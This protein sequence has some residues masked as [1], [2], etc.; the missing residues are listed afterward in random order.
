[1]NTLKFYILH[2][3]LFYVSLARN[4]S[5][6]YNIIFYT[7]DREFSRLARHQIILE[8]FVTSKY[9]RKPIY[10]NS[11]QLAKTFCSFDSR[12]KEKQGSLQRWR[13]NE[14]RIS[15]IVWYPGNRIV[16]TR[17]ALH[18]VLGT[19][20]GHGNGASTGCPSGREWHARGPR[21]RSHARV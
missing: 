12:T 13:T 4:L 19:R 5:N 11:S 20:R 10:Y 14:S 2:F 8:S 7:R 18:I 1:M 15:S 16:M 21:S 17:I 9:L 6:W 3:H